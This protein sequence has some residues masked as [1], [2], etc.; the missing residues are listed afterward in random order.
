MP[1]P[2]DGQ[3]LI[4]RAM[5]LVNLDS[6]GYNTDSR[7]QVAVIMSEFSV[8]KQRANTAVAHAAR[9]MRNIQLVNDPGPATF[10][11]RVRLTERQRERL[12][13]IADQETGGDMSAVV[14]KRLFE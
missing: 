13:L 5:Q 11:L 1:T 12:Q 14:R 9:R 3:Q 4:E 8:S 6:D 10:M 7:S 2:I